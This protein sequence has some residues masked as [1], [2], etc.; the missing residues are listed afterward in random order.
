[1]LSLVIQTGE[2]L[3]I[4]DDIL[5]LGLKSLSDHCKLSRLTLVI[6]GRI[7][8]RTVLLAPNLVP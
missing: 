5:K 8:I 7:I 1:M 2:C 3:V 6:S 4:K